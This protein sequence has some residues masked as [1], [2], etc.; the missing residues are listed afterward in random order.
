M[1]QIHHWAA[2]LFVAAMIVHMLRVFFTGGV[3]Q[4]ARAQLAA[5]R[6]PAD[7]RHRRGLRRLLAAGRPALRHR[8]ADR[9]RDHAVDPGRRHLGGVRGVRRRVPRRR[10]HPAALHRPRP[11]HTRHHPGADRA[12]TSVLVVLQKHTQFPG[13]GRREDNVVGERMY[14]SYGAKAGGFFFLVFGVIGAA[15]RALPDQPGLA[16]RAVQ[17]G[18]GRR[19]H[20]TRLVHGLPGRLDPVVPRL[21]DQVLELHDL[22]A[23]L[24]D[25]GVARDPVHA[26]SR[27]IRSSKRG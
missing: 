2:L 13:P 14:P 20:A 6:R 3:P 23:V 7:A 18:A 27:C 4:A 11:A 1:R 26:C 16:V 19:R 21:G 17:P 24:A 9:P 8:P 25:G 22:A 12:C 10:D 5:R 15:R